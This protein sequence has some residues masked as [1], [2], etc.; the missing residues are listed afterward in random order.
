ME[1][2]KLVMLEGLP[3]TGKTTNAHFLLMQLELS[4]NST[5]WI[6][7]VARPHPV[8]FFNEA[9]MTYGEYYSFLGTHPQCEQVLNHIAAFRKNTVGIDLYELQWNHINSIGMGAFQYLQEFDAWKFPV[10]KQVEISLDKWAYF[11]EKALEKEDICILDSSIFQFQIF[12]F[13]FKNTP[14]TELQDFIQKLIYI[15]KPLN[16][17]LIYFYRDN[18][19]DT[20]DFLEKLRGSHF[21]EDI[22][23]RDKSEPYYSDKPKGAEGQRCFL[24]DYASI[25]KRLFDMADCRKTA[26]EITKQDWV[27]Y[28]NKMLSFLEIERKSPP[29]VFPPIGV[30][31]NSTLGVELEIQGLLLI[32]PSG[33]KRELTPKSDCEFYVENLP[34]ILR[35]NGLDE[36]IILGG[37][38]CE[39][40]TT[41]GTLF[42]RV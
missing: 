16:P 31:T 17:N 40:W 39:P 27:N 4:K 22:W 33:V 20:I 3:G 24:K 21:M 13:L 38:I 2:T 12:T 25:A 36:I 29:N 32:D 37:Q 41:S 18:V 11:V 42:I 14:Y 15:I 6:H 8:L 9:C 34:V 26:I 23:E 5:K 35:F 19:D 10:N 28:E 7:E 1:N 30:Y